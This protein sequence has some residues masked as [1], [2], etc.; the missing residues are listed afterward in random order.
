MSKKILRDGHIHSPFCP[1]GSNDPLKEYVEKGLKIGL[2]EITFTE[3][4]PL[5]K[6]FMNQDFLDECSPSS[7]DFDKYLKETKSI[8]KE[9]QNEIKINIGCEVDYVEGYE[10]Q[11]ENILN[12]IGLEIED[13]ILSVHIVKFRDEYRCIDMLEDFEYL[14]SELKSLEEVYN[15]YYNT[16]LKSIKTDL[17]MY[18]PKRIGHPTLVRK[19]CMKYPYQYKNKELLEEVISE[20]KAKDYEIDYNT[21]GLRKEL[22]NE[23]YPTGLFKELVDKYNV[24]KV[25]GSDSHRAIDVGEGFEEQ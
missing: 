15:L 24:K 9:Y 8:K 20:I 17:G 1:H 7:K 12:G 4:L 23:V 13:S 19:F 5:P 18:K 10:D 16:L 6:G 2:R 25:Y 21:S 3:H 11:I 14:L 22:C